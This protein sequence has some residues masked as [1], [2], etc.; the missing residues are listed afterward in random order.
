MT[1]LANFLHQA[2]FHDIDKIGV[3]GTRLNENHLD[4]KLF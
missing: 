2:F 1:P 3:N 4:P